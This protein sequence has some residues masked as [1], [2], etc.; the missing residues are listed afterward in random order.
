MSKNIKIEAK[1]QVQELLKNGEITPYFELQDYV[2]TTSEV[3]NVR[4]NGEFLPKIIEGLGVKEQNI[5]IEGK[6]HQY[7]YYNSLGVNL[8][9]YVR[10]YCSLLNL[11]YI[12][13]IVKSTELKSKLNEANVLFDTLSP[14]D[15]DKLED[16][17]IELDDIADE[18]EFT[19]IQDIVSPLTNPKTYLTTMASYNGEVYTIKNKELYKQAKEE[20]DGIKD[21]FNNGIFDCENDIDINSFNPNN[22]NW[23]Y[24]EPIE[25]LYT[26]CPN[27]IGIEQKWYD[28]SGVSIDERDLD[29]AI[30]DSLLQ[31]SDDDKFITNITLLTNKK[32]YDSKVPVYEMAIKQALPI[33]LSNTNRLAFKVPCMTNVGIAVLMKRIFFNELRKDNKYEKAVKD[34]F[35][36]I[37]K[38]IAQFKQKLCCEITEHN[39]LPVPTLMFENNKDIKFEK[40]TFNIIEE[41]K[42]LNEQKNESPMENEDFERIE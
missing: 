10:T 27:G 42:F 32:D 19:F 36:M 37:L 13:D 29:D 20:I 34:N 40:D 17:K 15:K 23:Q 35:D 16:L 24:P 6:Y 9:D 5:K 41:R 33:T 11:K 28:T 12:C 30:D 1:E 4:N 31:P 7:F 2:I 26:Y 38:N 8:T 21:L 25:I 18:I 39:I 22:K 14:N 3:K